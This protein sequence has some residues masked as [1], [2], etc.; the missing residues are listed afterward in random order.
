MRQ[1]AWLAV[2]VLAML[3]TL[4]LAEDKEQT[5]DELRAALLTKQK[6]RQRDAKPVE[7]VAR[8]YNVAD[9]AIPPGTD[10]PRFDEVIAFIRREAGPQSWEREGAAIKPYDATLSLVIRQTPGVHEKIA[11]ALGRL[12]RDGSTQVTSQ[13]VLIA[14][15]RAE[16]AALAERFPGEFGQREREDLLK[17]VEESETLELMGRPQ[18]RA[19]T[20]TTAALQVSSQDNPQTGLNLKTHYVVSDDRRSI[21]LKISTCHS[22]D[23]AEVIANVQ[24]L[25]LHDGR[26]A[27]VHFESDRVIPSL[28][29]ADN[30]RELLV[31]VT[32]RVVV[33]KEQEEELLGIP[34][35]DASD[36]ELFITVK[37]RV[38]VQEEDEELV[39]IP[40]ESK[41]IRATKR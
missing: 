30:A 10:K 16:I 7:L 33:Q 34:T 32:P 20:H 21:R 17:A 6:P 40:V 29:P 37:P 4:A 23:A 38:I 12:R 15:P 24:F 3:G 14:G 1:F 2:G 8:T 5:W 26:T 28:P 31:L 36:E 13:F 39:E 19:V 11:D 9:M 25:T 27:A 41:K 35:S 22:D 18:V